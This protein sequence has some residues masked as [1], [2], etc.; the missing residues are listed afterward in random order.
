MIKK[1][2]IVIDMQND[3]YPQGAMELVGIIKANENVNELISDFREGG[4]EVIFIQH[5][6]SRNAPF[7]RK[8]SD[9]AKLFDGLD[10]KTSD[11]VFEKHYPNSFRD[12][13][14]DKYLQNKEIGKLVICGAM[15]HMCID[16]TVRAG[17]DLGYNI[18]LVANACATK[19]LAYNGEVIKA[20]LVHKSFLSALNGTFCEM[21]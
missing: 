13:D 21:I 7:F 2:L 17:F 16:T 19:D 11:V 1:A 20:D 6:A 14:L 15:T 10:I 4:D 3:Y 18:D 5:I 9:G 8:G 12:T